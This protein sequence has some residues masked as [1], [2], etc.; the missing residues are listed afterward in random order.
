MAA[1]KVIPGNSNNT[2]GHVYTE[3]PSSQVGVNHRAGEGVGTICSSGG[4]RRWEEMST[5]R[6]DVGVVQDG[7]YSSC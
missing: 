7:K 3:L 1:G 6:S 5:E 2:C 4:E